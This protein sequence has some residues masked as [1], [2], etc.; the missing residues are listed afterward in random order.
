[1]ETIQIERFVV[2]ES[3]LMLDPAI[4]RILQNV[5]WQALGRRVDMLV[6]TKQPMV[7]TPE[8]LRLLD[9]D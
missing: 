1:M 4:E 3:V 5:R 6:A 9:W 2:G 7:L 8:D